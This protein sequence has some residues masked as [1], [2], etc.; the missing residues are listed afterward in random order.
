MGGTLANDAAS[1]DCSSPP[2]THTK[3][4]RFSI[5]SGD[6]WGSP[7]P[8]QERGAAESVQSAGGISTRTQLGTG[9]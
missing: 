8:E 3:T 5:H 9:V 2:H 1:G 7:C 4:E 6:T